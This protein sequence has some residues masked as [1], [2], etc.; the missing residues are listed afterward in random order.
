M[1]LECVPFKKIPH[2]CPCATKYA[3]FHWFSF[4]NEFSL[5]NTIHHCRAASSHICSAASF[6]QQNGGYC[7]EQSLH[8][9]PFH[10]HCRG[11]RLDCAGLLNLQPGISL[12]R[13]CHA[14]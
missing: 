1:Q 13:T 4:R 7:D 9:S 12:G 8:A 11:S 5:T 3:Q 10:C 6:E 14:P 2:F